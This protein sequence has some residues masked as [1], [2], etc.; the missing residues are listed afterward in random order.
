MGP[1]LFLIFYNGLTDYFSHS[2]RL[3]YVDDT[4]LYYANNEVS[5]VENALNDDLKR[6]SAFCYDN[7]LILNLKKPK[8]EV[9]LCGSSKNLSKCRDL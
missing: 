9:I 2:K 7:E 5:W 8:T 1:L 3:Q 4:V 6:I